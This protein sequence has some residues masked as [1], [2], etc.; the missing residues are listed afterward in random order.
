MVYSIENE[1][2][3]ASNRTEPNENIDHN[4]DNNNGNDN[5]QS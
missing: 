5:V 3:T 2:T 4:D 1:V